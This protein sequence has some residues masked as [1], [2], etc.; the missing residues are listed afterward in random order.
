MGA[1]AK[2]AEAEE[3]QVLAGL[4]VEAHVRHIGIQRPLV[5]GV[6]HAPVM[7]K[8]HHLLPLTYRPH[9]ARQPLQRTRQLSERYLLIQRL[10]TFPRRLHPTVLHLPLEPQV[11]AAT[12][13]FRV[14][15]LAR[16][17]PASRRRVATG[18]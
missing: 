2:G 15:L 10:D 8:H 4:A 17:H 11:K 1:V 16:L 18:T 5:Q 13:R 6:H 3:A 9:Q 14:H 12:G 7:C